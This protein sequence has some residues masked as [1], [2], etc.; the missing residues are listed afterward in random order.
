MLCWVL[1]A[2]AGTLSVHVAP[3][4]ATVT[5]DGEVRGTGTM[6]LPLPDG[7]HR[8]RVTAEAF[9]PWEQVVE[10]KASTCVAVTLARTPARFD[11]DAVRARQTREEL[12][13]E[14]VAES[15]DADP[16]T[17]PTGIRQRPR[18][19]NPAFRTIPPPAVAPDPAGPPPWEVA[20]PCPPPAPAA[21]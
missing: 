4:D 3:R 14:M 8:L 16:P 1:A 19:Q 12:L 9:Q 6:D 10:V 20:E 15:I 7:A 2:T 18:D 13:S 17:D 5:V 21:P 11:A